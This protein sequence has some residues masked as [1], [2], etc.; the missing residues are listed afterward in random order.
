MNKQSLCLF[1]FF[2]VFII[3]LTAQRFPWNNPTIPSEVRTEKLLA[4]LRTNEKIRLLMYDNPAIPRLGLLEYNW[5]NE[6]LHGVA[7]N[8]IAT[9]FPQAINLAATF[10][11]SLVEEVATNISIEARAKYNEARK[12]KHYGQYAGLTFWSPNIN[13]FRDQRWGRGQETYGEDP[14]LTARMGVAFVKGLQGTDHEHPRAAA[15]AKHYAVH[16][17]PEELRHSF[18]ASPSLKDFNET[19]LP[20]F[21]ALVSEAKVE[22]VMCAYNRL[23]GSPCCGSD[24]L[25]RS[26]L[27][28]EWGFSGYVVSDCAAIADIYYH[29][30]AASSMEEA[31]AQ[32]LKAGVNLDCGTEFSHLKQAL[33]RKLITKKEIDDALVPLLN[34]RIRLGNLDPFGSNPLDTLNEEDIHSEIAIHSAFE[35]AVRSIVLLKND[36]SLPLKKE[37]LKSISLIGP[38][39]DDELV[40]IGNYFGT[41]PE[42]I[43]VKDGISSIGGTAIF[44]NISHSFL[45]NSE[46]DEH[47]MDA[48]FHSDVTIVAL[49]LNSSLQGESGDELLSG[50]SGDYLG[51]EIPEN[52]IQFLRR[53]RNAISGPIIGLVFGGGPLLLEEAA[54]LCNGLLWCG[55]PGEQGGRAIAELLFGLRSPSGKLPFTIPY[56]VDQL[57]AFDDYSMENRTYRFINSTPL[58]PF[59]YGLCYTEFLFQKVKISSQNASVGDTIIVEIDISNAGKLDGT[60]IVQLYLRKLH[61]HKKDP[62]NKLV[63]F[64][65]ID[66]PAGDTRQLRFELSPESFT[67]YDDLGNPYVERG[68]YILGFVS[69]NRPDNEALRRLEKSIVLR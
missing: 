13:I 38:L 6:A 4:E 21:R 25:L 67:S 59:G 36:G 12:I 44:L 65:S 50:K 23:Y 31:A 45:T 42:L 40:L 41:S 16:S 22:G 29:H 48:I 49:G 1:L 5:W 24:T 30:N 68:Q 14:F 35:A 57:P 26:I 54:N 34:L 18:N 28:N 2:S 43:T 17:G 51:L 46:Y 60:E 11:D 10:N 69:S 47:T 56:T 37:E 19:Y 52:Q 33:K 15:C 27:R 53:L 62:Y 61:P 66:I 32:S 7:R 64:K 55:Y 8:G 39:A 9:V 58:Y 3:R 63:A 20:A